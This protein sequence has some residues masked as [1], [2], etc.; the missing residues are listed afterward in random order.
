MPPPI[1]SFVLLAGA[2]GGAA[3]LRAWARRPAP[4]D[5]MTRTWVVLAACFAL[6]AA[7]LSHALPA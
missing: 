3:A 5:P 2:S 7:W 4:P 6:V 1:L